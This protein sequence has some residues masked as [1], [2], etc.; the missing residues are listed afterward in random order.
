MTID[1]TINTLHKLLKGRVGDKITD[2]RC[3]GLAA[4]L[5]KGGIRLEWR[6]RIRGEKNPRPSGWACGPT[7]W[8]GS[9]ARPMAAP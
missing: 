9:F 8:I 1:F 6:G 3:P 2:A 7:N 5:I 4:R